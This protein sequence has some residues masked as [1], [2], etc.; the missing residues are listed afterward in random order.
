MHRTFTVAQVALQKMVADM[1][2]PRMVNEEHYIDHMRTA[3]K[4]WY[5]D[6]LKRG[7]SEML[8]SPEFAS[9]A[10][11]GVKFPEMPQEDPNYKVIPME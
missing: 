2:A 1:V 9:H 11:T 3:L 6:A 4:L 7:F 10:C 5:P 8:D